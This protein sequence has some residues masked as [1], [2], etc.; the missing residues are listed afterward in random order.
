MVFTTHII[1]I[2]ANDLSDKTSLHSINYAKKG[3][4]LL[5]VIVTYKTAFYG[6]FLDCA[7]VFR[8]RL[9][10]V[11]PKARGLFNEEIGSTGDLKMF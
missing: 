6:V 1:L 11:S 7:F 3:Y 9:A 2:P 4:M 10:H 5:F 8:R